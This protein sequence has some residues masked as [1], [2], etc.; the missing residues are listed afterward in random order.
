MAGR[1]L[2]GLEAG[3]PAGR[4]KAAALGHQEAVGGDARGG[5][6]V[7]AAPAP[8]LDVAQP[9]LLLELLEVALDPPPQLRGRDQLLQ[10]GCFVSSYSYLRA[11]LT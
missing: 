5:V 7:A 8:A 9:Q 6:V 4:G 3:S 2:G 10:R 11:C 1:P